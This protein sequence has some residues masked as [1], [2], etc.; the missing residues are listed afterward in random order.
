[1]DS[2]RVDA[3]QIQ[4]ELP[5]QM[6]QAKRWL[7][8]REIPVPGK[9]SRKVP[10]YMDGKPREET[11]TPEDAA[12]LVTFEQVVPA[13]ESGKYAGPGFALG[14]DGTGNYWQGADLD[15]LSLNG[16]LRPLVEILPGFVERSP[17]GDGVHALGVGKHFAPMGSNGSGVEAYASGRFFTVTGDAIGG[18]LE[19]ISGFVLSTLQPLHGK[20][21][22]RKADDPDEPEP[23][24]VDEQVVRDLRA[25]LGYLDADDREVWVSAAH[26]L[27]ELGSVGFGLWN[28]WALRSEK[29]D[30][31]DAARVWQSVKGERT[32]YKAI[33]AKAQRAGWVN[34]TRREQHGAQGAPADFA[35]FHPNQEQISEI[36][37][38]S[39][40]VSD[41]EIPKTP[42]D[43]PDPEALGH[44]LG[45]SAPFPVEALPEIIRD[46]VT[47]YAAYGK[48]PLPMIASSA[49]ATVSLV[50]QGHADIA[51]DERLTGPIS[52]SVASIASSGERKSAADKTFSAQIR[53]AI[54]EL[55]TEAEE[56][57]KAAQARLDSWEA[58]RAGVKSALAN[59]EKGILPAQ[60][61][62]PSGQPITDAM[63]EAARQRLLLRNNELAERRPVVPTMP[64]VLFGD[65][66]LEALAQKMQ[67]S[68]PVGALWEDEGGQVIGSVGFREER[69]L[70]FLTAL[71]KLWDGTGFT[72]DRA[73]VDDREM[74]GKRL[75][76]N[77]MFQPAVLDKL[78]SLEAG[79]ARTQGFLARMLICE[80]TSTMGTRLYTP[81]KRLEAVDA[82]SRRALELFRR[83]L[84]LS[85]ASE[86]EVDPP[87]MQLDPDAK[88]SWCDYHDLVEREL[89]E[90]GD[91]VDVPDFA[92]KSAEQ[93]VRIA[94]NFHLFA[95]H[96]PGEAVSEETMA[97]A[98]E[99]AAW[100]LDETL[101]IIR[102]RA[103]PEPIRDAVLVWEWAKGLETF[104]TSDLI[105]YGPNALRKA[106][107][108]REAAL[109]ELERHCLI[110][111]ARQG[112]KRTFHINP[113]AQTDGDS[114][115]AA[116]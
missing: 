108:R 45:E 110:A 107:D 20:P 2:S 22:A 72:Q 85:E 92:S 35:D 62:P 95:G 34:S 99:V 56:T 18:D 66:S 11:D 64:R 77:L 111:C 42:D 86:F 70:A 57:I 51:R 73:S 46:A 28:E 81:P 29:Y 88:K 26:A 87:V 98:R 101:R 4:A 63:L 24:S 74:F 33:F 114:R 90:C 78:F 97:S 47:A 75:T 44:A 52:L 48:Q 54:R 76:V 59:I 71:S 12:R 53:K 38:G 116:A 17:S 69:L 40:C 104:T 68:L 30:A 19:D 89:G 49:L 7:L 14:D 15:G 93:A 32:G 91:L 43:W 80:P 112:K 1:M 3:A 102:G 21:K 61:K 6:L 96:E 60:D 65:A 27:H 103:T 10:Y 16:H 9:K 8:W 13:L 58:M 37:K 25:A 105:N 100:Y 36:S 79:L 83:P 31:E 113:K 84:P 67:R 115:Q 5:E 82:F 41:S 106:K 109:K 55:Q 39:K 94:G 50:C 23:V